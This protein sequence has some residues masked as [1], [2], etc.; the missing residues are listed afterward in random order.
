MR[1]AIIKPIY[2]LRSTGV[3]YNRAMRRLGTPAAR[4]I[5]T[6][7]IVAAI[8]AGYHRVNVNPATVGFTFIVAVLVVSAYWGLPYAVLLAFT[9][10]LAYNFFFL[11]PTGTFTIS[12]PQN[13]IALFAFLISALLASNL[14]ERARRQAAYAN[15]R[16]LEVER[17]YAFSQQLLAAD[18]VLELLNTMPARIVERFGVNTAALL[19]SSRPDLY[20]SSLPRST[21]DAR[22][23]EGRL[24]AAL[25]RGESSVEQGVSYVPLR[26]GVRVVGALAVADGSLTRETLEAISTLVAIAVER[27]GA[28]E[29]LTKTQAARENE[30][31]RS[32]LLDSVT[33]EFRTPLTGIKA[34]VTSLLSDAGLG[35]EEKKE[36]L[37]V[38]NEESD[39]LD[40]LVGE[41]AEMAQLDSGTFT[42]D[43]H[44]H[45][46]RKVIDTAISEA[47]SALQSHPVEVI[48]A[49]NLP[50]APMDIDRIRE[51]LM[52]LLG[53]AGK[54]SPE[55]APV[56]VTA[57]VKNDALVI[58][59]AD[60][61]PGVDSFEQSLIFD[62]FYRGRTQRYAAPGTGMGLAIAKI[63]V[64][65][66]KGS[67]EVI[68]Q[69][70]SGS[71]FSFSLPLT[72]GATL[73]GHA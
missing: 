54:Y 42:L 40:R 22:I 61:G 20:R 68:S 63:I 8:T 19:L 72:A 41:A 39:R 44:M 48:A 1:Q 45:D 67:I 16:R 15:Q 64:E 52:H 7:F 56:R 38:I 34:S 53:N 29:A 35:S 23:D 17:L 5:T 21:E 10:T 70:G 49:D 43:I 50:Q 47:R 46:V 26:L 66:H 2:R 31:L 59:V 33:H 60:H 24:K 12:D 51:V 71:V 73:T 25:A 18:N 13:W 57:E 58:S 9:A 36:L 62:K 65:A 30:E 32:A 28:V 55:G 37:T 3:D 27:A 6:L 4:W 14:A 69:P 11:P